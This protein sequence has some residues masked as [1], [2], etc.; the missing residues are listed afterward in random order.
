MSQKAPETQH[1]GAAQGPSL[2]VIGVG[3]RWDAEPAA[4]PAVEQSGRKPAAIR[5]AGVSGEA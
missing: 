4:G 2:G 5:D 1:S 3:F